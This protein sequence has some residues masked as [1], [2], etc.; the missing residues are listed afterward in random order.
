[1]GSLIG[2]FYLGLKFSEADH[3]VMVDMTQKLKGSFREGLSHLE[4]LDN[5]TRTNAIQKLDAIEAVIGWSGADP[6]VVSSTGL[7]RY[8]ADIKI[9]PRDYY[10]TIDQAIRSYAAKRLAQPGKKSVRQHMSMTPQTNNAEY[11]PMANR[12]SIPAGI[13]QPPMYTT[14]A[15][16]YLNLGGTMS[17][18]VHEIGHAFDAHGRRFDSKG[19]LRNYSNFTITTSANKTLHVN[20]HL[21]IGENIADHI[22]TKYAFQTWLSRYQC[23]RNA[24]EE[25]IVLTDPHAP[26]RWRVNGPLINYPVFAET[27]KCASGSRMNPVKKC[28]IWYVYVTAKSRHFEADLCYHADLLKHPTGSVS[29]IMKTIQ[30]ITTYRGITA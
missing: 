13:I 18:I 9:K 30:D 26:P 2:Y 7:E 11:N 4:W 12:V 28:M 20:G 24:V 17:V 19:L 25:E 15:P 23:D 6:N 22:A 5:K 10:G 16:E 14:G 8:F 3:K 21:I 29:D 1:M 27:L